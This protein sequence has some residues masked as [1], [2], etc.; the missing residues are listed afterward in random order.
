M[1]PFSVAALGMSGI[2]SIIGARSAEDQSIRYL[3]GVRETNQTNIQIA[4]EQNQANYEQWLRESAWNRKQWED[5]NQWN[6]QQWNR[7]NEYNS[8]AQ[9]MARYR[10]AGIN[11]YYAMQGVDNA[12]ANSAQAS[13]ASSSSA[14]PA[15]GAQQIAPDIAAY[16]TFGSQLGKSF[17]EFSSA[18]SAV[19]AARSQN[20]DASRKEMENN[21]FFTEFYLKLAKMNAE[22]REMKDK[23]LISSKELSWFD[24]IQQANLDVANQQATNLRQNSLMAQAQVNDIFFRQGIEHER[25]QLEKEMQRF[26]MANQ[27]KLTYGQLEL[28]SSQMADLFASVNLKREQQ[29]LTAQQVKSEILNGAE[30]I[31]RTNGIKWDNR[32]KVQS[33][34]WNSQFNAQ[35]LRSMRYSVRQQKQNYYNPFHYFGSVLGGSAAA[36]IKLIK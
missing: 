33:L 26:S 18:L 10:A 17:S 34:Y 20:A 23:H 4:R 31:A 1:D 3:R 24:K 13:P 27:M 29:N 2:G 5:T 8:P 12:S 15:V 36:G 11:P 21:N 35:E 25:L 9:M 16:N 19:A 7:E 32:L 28:W 6:L 22:I 14:A 30:T